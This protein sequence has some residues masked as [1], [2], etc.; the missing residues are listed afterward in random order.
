MKDSSI[1]FMP[2]ETVQFVTA[3]SLIP[4]RG[5]QIDRFKTFTEENG[6]KIDDF[7]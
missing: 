4:A 7:T 5:G 3:L 2:G 6:A 1:V